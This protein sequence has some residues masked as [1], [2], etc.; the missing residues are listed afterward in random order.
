MFIKPTAVDELS[1]EVLEAD[2]DGVK[3]R[4]LKARDPTDCAWAT[5]YTLEG[6]SVRYVVSLATLLPD[7]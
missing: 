4:V 7:L 5:E 2:P 3:P 1:A 6:Q